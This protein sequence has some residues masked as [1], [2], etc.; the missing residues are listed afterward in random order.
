MVKNKTKKLKDRCVHHTSGQSELLLTISLLEIIHHTSLYLFQGA[1]LHL[2]FVP[3]YMSRLCQIQRLG[4]DIKGLVSVKLS[5]HFPFVITSI[6]I[7]GTTK[8]LTES[9]KAVKAWGKH[10]KIRSL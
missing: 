2:K 4:L 1:Q 5:F 8:A 7:K 10:M 9:H 6:V 3:S